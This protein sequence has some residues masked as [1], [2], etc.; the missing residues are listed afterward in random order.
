MLGKKVCLL[1]LAV[2]LQLFNLSASVFFSLK[3]REL[4]RWYCMAME[5]KCG[6]KWWYFGNWK[7]HWTNG[8]LTKNSIKEATTE[9]DQKQWECELPPNR[10]ES[11]QNEN[12]CSLQPHGTIIHSL[13]M[14]TVTWN[15]ICWETHVYPQNPALLAQ[16]NTK[17]RDRGLSNTCLSTDSFIV[18][19]I[20]SEYSCQDSSIAWTDQTPSLHNFYSSDLNIS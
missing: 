6:T 9:D 15:G 3:M 14:P 5:S 8:I 4:L 7:T 10:N 2:S 20:I 1:T 11:N 13:P 18:E 17:N 19:W 12:G 16:I